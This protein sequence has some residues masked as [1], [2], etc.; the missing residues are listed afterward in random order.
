VNKLAKYWC[1]KCE[2]DFDK[3]QS[4]DYG[5]ELGSSVDL[6]PKCGNEDYEWA[7][8]YKSKEY[9][10]KAYWDLKHKHNKLISD[11]RSSISINA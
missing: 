1:P 11:I 4:V 7:D 6:C 2:H 5:A 8:G 3:P 10:E 9:W